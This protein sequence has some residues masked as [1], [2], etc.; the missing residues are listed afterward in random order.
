MSGMNEREVQNILS[1]YNGSPE[2]DHDLHLRFCGVEILRR[3]IGLAQI[4]S[5][6]TLTEKKELIDLAVDLVNSPETHYFFTYEMD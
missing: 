6:F 2:F 5:E 1:H 3:I 4:P